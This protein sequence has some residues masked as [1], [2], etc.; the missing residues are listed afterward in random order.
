MRRRLPTAVAVLTSFWL[1]AGSALALT[2]VRAAPAPAELAPMASTAQVALLPLRGGAPIRL[3]VHVGPGLLPW[4]EALSP[5]PAFSALER[6]WTRRPLPAFVPQ[7]PR[8][9]APPRA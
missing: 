9:R 1:A 2:P 3:G 5:P 8:A 6:S 4:V 7:L